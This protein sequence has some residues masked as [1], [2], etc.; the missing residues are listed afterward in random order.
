MS[1]S[2]PHSAAGVALTRGR[3][4]S[5][6]SLGPGW[7]GGRWEWKGGGEGRQETVKIGW[8]GGAKRGS[9]G[10]ESLER[11]SR[12]VCFIYCLMRLLPSI[13]VQQRGGAWSHF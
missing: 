3:L 11:K 5:G 1:K 9:A 6:P 12:S 13:P 8:P 7:L 10:E 2:W 4:S